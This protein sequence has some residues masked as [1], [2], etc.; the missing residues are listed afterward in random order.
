MHTELTVHMIDIEDKIW[1]LTKTSH[2]RLPEYLCHTAIILMVFAVLI[3]AFMVYGEHK[4]WITVGCL[5]VILVLSCCIHAVGK[6]RLH[7]HLDDKFKTISLRGT[8]KG[9]AKKV[10]M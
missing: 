2:L 7:N 3:A 10:V 9:S 6:R 5:L 8:S 1:Y 4:A